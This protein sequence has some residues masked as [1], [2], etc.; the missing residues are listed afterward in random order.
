MRAEVRTVRLG[1]WVFAKSEMP[2][3]AGLKPGFSGESSKV[4]GGV[5]SA[6]R[7][8]KPS[9]AEDVY[10]PYLLQLGLLMRTPKGRVVTEKGRKHLQ[11]LGNMI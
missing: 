1:V 10:E 5:E 9:V 8:E 7:I 3:D 4:V 6:V 2:T 11:E